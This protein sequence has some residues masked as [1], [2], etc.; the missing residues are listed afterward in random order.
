MNLKF[1]LLFCITLS[2][3]QVYRYV[4]YNFS[5]IK[6]YKIFPYREIKSSAEHHPFAK[7]NMGLLPSTINGLSFDQFL[8]KNHTVA[9]LIIKNDTIQYENY[10]YNYHP[11]SL[12]P[13]FSVAKSVLSLLIGCAIE[14]GFIISVDDPITKY[15]PELKK[16]NFEKVKIK[17]LLQMTSGIK[18]SENYFSPFSDAARYYYGKNLRKK[19][20]KM[21]LK[22]EPGKKFE[23]HSGN[24]QLLG[25]VLERALKGKSI[26]E[27]LQEKIWIPLGMESDATWSLDWGNNPIEKTFCCL[28]A[29]ATDFAKIGRL[30]IHEG[31][32]QGKRIISK[33]WITRILKPENSEGSASYYQYSWWLPQPEQTILAEGHLGQYVYVYPNKKLII[34]RFGKNSGR[35]NWW[36]FFKELAN[37]Y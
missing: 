36:K 33:D 23:Y 34:V 9:F 24:S 16:N 1:F 8:K 11:K 27:Y 12:I 31:V 13:S 35:I 2:S 21:K 3:C 29:T 20:L 7:S 26:S 32:Y 28:N 37:F 5:D 30:F 22:N 6:D 19:L 18:F 14:D 17:H 10:F 15:I 25:L 4:Y